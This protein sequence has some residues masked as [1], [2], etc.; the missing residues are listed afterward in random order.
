VVP[1]TIDTLAREARWDL[2][3]LTSLPGRCRGD[4]LGRWGENL[5]RRFGPDAH[6]RV[7]RRVGSPF[8]AVAPV[9]TAKDWVPE[10]AQLAL[11]EAIVDEFLGGDMRALYPLLL[12][13]TRAGLGRIQVLAVK[14]LG[15]GRV[16]ARGAA[17]FSD[18]YERGTA[19]S[20]IDRGRARVTFR[21]SPLFANPTWRLLQL[22]ATRTV[23]ELA[24]SPGDVSGEHLGD[25][26]FA[27]LAT[28]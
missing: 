17:G 11:T 2:A 18:I 27:T 4:A 20:Q 19:E 3:K 1:L 23:M 21:G 22:F 28:W 5:A 8:D 10:G 24:G 15:A 7:R 13:D 25:D 9:L 26:A 12:E 14:A 6:S 16:L